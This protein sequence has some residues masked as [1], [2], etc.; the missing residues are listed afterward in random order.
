MSGCFVFE[1]SGCSCCFPAV[2]EELIDLGNWGGRQSCK[3]ICEIFE[4]IDFQSTAGLDDTHQDCGSLSAIG[5]AHEQPVCSS[6]DDRS[7]GI[8]A[9]IVMHF[10]ET[11]IEELAQR[12]PAVQ[13]VI[14]GIFEC[15][16]SGAELL[17]IE[18]TFEVVH[19]RLCHSLPD[20]DAL[21]FWKSHSQILN[22]EDAFDD[23][24]R[25][26]GEVFFCFFGIFKV[27]VDVSQA[28]GRGS[29]I[30]L[31]VRICENAIVDEGAV[32]KEEA[33][34]VRQETG[35]VLTLAVFGEIVEIVR[36]EFVAAI[37]RDFALDCF[38]GASAD[39]RHSCFVGLNHLALKDESLHAFVQDSQQI[40]FGLEPAAHGGARDWNTM[41]QENLLL[42][43]QW[44]VVFEF[45]LCDINDEFGGRV[46]SI[47]GLNR[48]IRRYDILL[49]GRAGVGVLHVSDAWVAGGNVAE[50]V[51]DFSTDLSATDQAVRTE[52]VG[53]IGYFV[54]LDNLV[55]SASGSISPAAGVSRRRRL[56]QVFSFGCNSAAGLFVH[57]FS[58]ALNVIDVYARRGRS[59]DVAI[60][61]AHLF[62]KFEDAVPKY[63]KQF[64]ACRNC[65]RQGIG[66][67]NWGSRVG[68]IDHC[69]CS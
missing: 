4:R 60:A 3:H 1:N 36:G 55:F 10:Q 17:F 51:R 6:K 48:F 49:A 30:T 38:A 44:Q 46:A 67:D 2:W 61:S 68:R 58:F 34:V 27:S 28:I 19:E 33:F 20:G 21:I 29:T 37:E 23:A 69:I 24:D 31:F 35:M 18:P 59:V 42:A 5:R 45:G 53:G 63:G 56:S 41:A 9:V 65:V 64:V 16:R 43:I 12:C 7:E 62:F 8:F 25:V 47:D 26:V 54:F 32:T 13:R 57:F 39:E 14:D 40:G 15:S 50:L 11:V 66:Q 52:E 22:F